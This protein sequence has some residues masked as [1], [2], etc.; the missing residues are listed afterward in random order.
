VLITANPLGSSN[1]IA[2]LTIDLTAISTQT[3]HS[4][5]QLLGQGP[6]QKLSNI[7]KQQQE[8]VRRALDLHL[9]PRP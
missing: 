8:G 7:A 3:A 6:P 2:G 4:K 1:K 9:Q 5:S